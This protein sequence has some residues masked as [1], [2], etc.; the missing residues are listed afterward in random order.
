MPVP[1]SIY[2]NHIDRDIDKNDHCDFDE[3]KEYRKAAAERNN[4]DDDE[5]DSDED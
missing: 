3:N 5:Q 2:Q 4:S 1:G